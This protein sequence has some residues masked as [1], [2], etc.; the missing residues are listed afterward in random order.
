MSDPVLDLSH[1]NKLANAGFADMAADGVIGVIH[2]C[3]E[4]SSYVD[5]TY[6]MRRD[7]AEAAGLLWGA[8][9]FLRPGDMRE[10]AQHFV[11]HAGSDVG[12]LY[13]ADHEDPEVSLADLKDFLRIVH[14][15][16]G[17]AP[18][19]YSGHVIKEQ[20]GSG[21]DPELARYPLWLAHYSDRPSWPDATWPMWWLWQ[22]TEL[23]QSAG[24]AGAVDCNR[25]AGELD[26]LRREWAS[27][28]APADQ[29]TVTITVDA[30][31]NVVVKVV[32]L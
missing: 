22:Y 3:T 26:D 14:D 10:Q 2:K 25:Y 20:L 28:A 21:A 29:V 27:D 5:D 4:G 9:H 30:P 7:Q 11:Q 1:W 15:L 17:H 32:R 8:Y 16:T 31:P 6:T 23:G 12:L 18:V 13:A 19:L 24:V